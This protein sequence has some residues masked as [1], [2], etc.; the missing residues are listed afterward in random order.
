ML[1]IVRDT[2]TESEAILQ[3]LR[4]I[5]A[6]NDLTLQTV[7]PAWLLSGHHDRSGLVYV[8]YVDGNNVRRA[9]KYRRLDMSRL[10]NLPITIQ[11]TGDYSA[12]L[13]TLINA[14]RTQLKCPLF[15]DGIERIDWEDDR[16]VITPRADSYVYD[17]TYTIPL[18]S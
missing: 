17:G 9:A 18:A 2:Q 13:E 14:V 15:A 8:G 10:P 12:D 3:I 6:E 7:S 5:T 16:V 11:L 4:S 1:H